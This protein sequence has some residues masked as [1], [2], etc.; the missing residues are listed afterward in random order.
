[1]HTSNEND[2]KRTVEPENEHCFQPSKPIWCWFDW[3]LLA[4]GSMSFIFFD[5]ARHHDIYHDSTKHKNTIQYIRYLTIQHSTDEHENGVWTLM[6]FIKIIRLF[7]VW[8]VALSIVFF[9]LHWQIANMTPCWWKSTQQN[10][11]HIKTNHFWD[12]WNQKPSKM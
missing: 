12:E 6:I 8:V 7:I 10:I 2:G 3:W 5:I 9:G 11:K 1:M 4:D